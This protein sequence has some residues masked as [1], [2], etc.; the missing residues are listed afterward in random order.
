MSNAIIYTRV[1]SKEQ[2]KSGLSLF[3]QSDTCH[4]FATSNRFVII[5][6]YSEV[7]SGKEGID[8]RIQLSAALLQAKKTKSII[9]ISKLDR[10]SRDVAFIS[11]LMSNGVPFIVVELGVNTDPFTLHLYAALAEKERSLISQRTKAALAACK[12]PLG[13]RT[14]LSTAQSLGASAN[15]AKSSSFKSTLLPLVQPLR[16]Q[17]QSLAYIANYLNL[18]KIKS[19]RGGEW[20]AKTVSRIFEN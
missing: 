8:K 17:G 9:I 19:A 20:S 2:G 14:N 5:G 3:A 18:L 7:A 16:D 10:L 12:K 11:A 6:E 13:N 15:A 4:Q 1:S